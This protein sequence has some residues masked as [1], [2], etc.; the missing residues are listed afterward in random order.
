[1]EKSLKS[2]GIDP[3]TV[4]TEQLMGMECDEGEEEESF[5]ESPLGAVSILGGII[6]IGAGIAYLWK[7]N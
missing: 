1:M 2:Q 4:N 3:K 6:A 5:I 7:R